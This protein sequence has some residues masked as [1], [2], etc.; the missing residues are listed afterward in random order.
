MNCYLCF[1][2]FSVDFYQYINFNLK[3]VLAKEFIYS[4]KRLVLICILHLAGGEPVFD[5]CTI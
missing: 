5:V 1:W 3:P 2:H 4:S